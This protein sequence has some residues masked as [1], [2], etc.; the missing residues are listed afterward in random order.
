MK[1]EKNESD[2]SRDFNFSR[3]NFFA[4][5]FLQF[6]FEKC[7]PTLNTS[8]Q[9]VELLTRLKRILRVQDVGQ[10]RYQKYICNTIVQIPNVGKW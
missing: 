1:C 8:A 2:F 5:F 10:V 7:Q 6:I 4:N 9:S 3:F